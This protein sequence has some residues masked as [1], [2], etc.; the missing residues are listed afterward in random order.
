MHVREHAIL[1]IFRR[2]GSER[3]RARKVFDCSQGRQRV[4]AFRTAGEVVLDRFSIC[5]VEPAHGI[6]GEAISHVFG[7][8]SQTGSSTSPE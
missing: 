5:L 7:F 1:Q 6:F 4:A 8:V 3:S 2:V